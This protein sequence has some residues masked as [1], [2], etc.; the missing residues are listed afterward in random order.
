LEILASIDTTKSNALIITQEIKIQ[1]MKIELASWAA[2]REAAQ[3]QC[4]AQSDC[5]IG[6][7]SSSHSSSIVSTSRHSLFCNGSIDDNSRNCSNASK[8]S[9]GFNSS[10]CY[11]GSYDSYVQF[12]FSLAS[13]LASSTSSTINQENTSLLFMSS[14]SSHVYR[15]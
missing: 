7:S 8:V 10:N 11:N 4:K 3:V 2:Q 12:Q 15:M 1:A 6:L 9:N 14:G 13:I 5:G